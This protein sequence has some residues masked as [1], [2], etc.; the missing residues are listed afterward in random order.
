MGRAVTTKGARRGRP[1]QLAKRATREALVDAGLAEFAARGLDAPSLDGICARAG[2]TRGAFYV[3]FRDRDDFL[4]AVAERALGSFVDAVIATGNHA[5]D[6]ERSV[7]RFLGAVAPAAA[8]DA[9]GRRPPSP[10]AGM[11]VHR[12]LEACARS[13]AI[14]ARVVAL[15]QGAVG[16]LAQ[17]AAAGQ[18]VH[19][20]RSDVDPQQAATMLV[21]AAIGI[22][23][24]AEIGMTLDFA[25]LRATVLALLARQPA[26]RDRPVRGRSADRH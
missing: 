24:A 12:L 20:V 5:H 25:G 2:Y 9:H 4:V 11:Q 18:G 15:V 10:L 13:T 8:P 14:R 19:A 22:L 16:R 7:E 3:H 17:V 1:R 23:T 6:L 26:E 21:A